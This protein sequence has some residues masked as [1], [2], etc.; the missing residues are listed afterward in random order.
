VCALVITYN[1]GSAVKDVVSSLVRQVSQVLVVDNG[2]RPD[3]VR[4]LED[5]AQHF[6]SVFVIQRNET[7]LGVATALN[8]GAR[9]ATELGFTWLLTVDQDSLPADDMVKT[10]VD[11]ERDAAG[12]D[13]VGIVAPYSIDTMTGKPIPIMAPRKETRALEADRQGGR[14]QGVWFVHTSGNLVNTDLF[15]HGMWFREDFFVDCV[16]FEFCLRI[17]KAGYRI[18]VA[19]GAG[20]RH[21]IGEAQTA[22]L[23]GKALTYSTHSP[24]RQYYMVRNAVVLYRETRNWR[25][26][27]LYLPFLV[28]HLGAAV[29]W[30]DA[31]AASLKAIARGFF[32]GVLGRMGPR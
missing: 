28:L 5:L 20:M 27:Q 23:W 19:R 24:A 21:T 1:A 14:L 11:A 26:L 15:R 7:N 4:I 31:K 2:S 29:I 17:A 9:Y 22:R 6:G 30:E 25:F 8:Q 16:D 12:G 32:D 13:R 3:T 10:M 18:V